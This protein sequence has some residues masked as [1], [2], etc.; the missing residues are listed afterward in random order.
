MPK[1]SEPE[2]GGTED[3]RGTP[4]RLPWALVPLR[5]RAFGTLVGGYALAGLGTGMAAV[6]ISWLA[7]SIAHGHDTALVIGGAVAA[8]SLPGVVA[9]LAFGKYFSRWDGRKL[10]LAEAILRAASLGTIAA[11]AWSGMLDPALYI[12]LLG[13][14]SLFGLLGV[15]GDL[16]AVVELLPADEHLAGNA[17]VTMAGFGAS[18]VGPALAGGLI[19]LAGAPSAIA[20]D[21]ATFMLLGVAAAASRR[22]QPPP[23][24]PPA[25]GIGVLTTLRSLVRLPSVL[26]ITALC[27]VYFG[28]YGPVEVALPVD[29]T[30]YLHA[31][32]GVLGGLWTLFAIG[33]TVGALGASAV[34]RFGVWRVIVVSVIGWGL[35]MVPL[36]LVAS[37]TIGFVALAAGG[38]CY[39]PF[40]PLKQAIIQRDTPA[41]SLTAVA[42]ASAMFTVPASPIGTAVGG[43]L[44]AAVGARTT[45]LGSGVLTV[46]LAVVVGAALALRRFRSGRPPG[47]GVRRTAERARGSRHVEA[48]P[49]APAAARTPEVPHTAPGL[50]PSMK[51]TAADM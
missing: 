19:A 24:E 38:L 35:C 25:A 29:V 43:P 7:I 26:G 16:A 17:L 49:R 46:A 15:A 22:F 4:R 50:P 2:G 23:A 48:S 34:E 12:T 47:P 36:G 1:R 30:S 13:V 41:G 44:V 51:Q 45:L 27:V 39:G 37:T 10:V 3:A 5:R 8:Y 21:A 31:G 18:I 40:L 33:A 9:W 11:L 42:A 28:I 6:A 14:S 32:A 20:A